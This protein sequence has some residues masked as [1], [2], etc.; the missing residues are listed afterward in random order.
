[1][2]GMKI[3]KP[4][5]PASNSSLFLLSAFFLW[6][7]GGEGGRGRCG[8]GDT[9]HVYVGHLTFIEEVSFKILC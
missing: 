5:H 9:T 3:V 1:M 8:G 4:L 6:R 7:Q 2:D